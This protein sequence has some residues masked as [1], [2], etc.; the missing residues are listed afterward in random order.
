[1]LLEKSD[2]ARVGQHSCVAATGHSWGVTATLKEV[3]VPRSGLPRLLHF[4]AL[5][6]SNY[7]SGKLSKERIWS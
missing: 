1:M 2:E 3:C 5:A 6:Y 4:I 7:L